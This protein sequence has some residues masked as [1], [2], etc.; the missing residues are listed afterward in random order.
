[1]LFWGFRG[2]PLHGAPCHLAAHSM[3]SQ[4]RQTPKGGFLADVQTLCLF[5]LASTDFACKDEVLANVARV[6]M[7]G[8][9]NGVMTQHDSTLN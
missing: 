4:Q 2:I 5:P 9:K 6:K 7:L 3:E 1:M 8:F